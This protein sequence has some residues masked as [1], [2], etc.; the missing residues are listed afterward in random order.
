[1]ADPAV[2]AG[3]TIELAEEDW[4]IGMPVRGEQR[5]RGRKIGRDLVRPL[6]RIVVSLS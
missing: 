1:V 2:A 3:I 5:S 4:R 6:V